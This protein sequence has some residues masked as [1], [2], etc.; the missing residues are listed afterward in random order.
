MVSEKVVFHPVGIV[1]IRPGKDNSVLIFKALKALT[2]IGIP[3][4]FLSFQLYRAGGKGFKMNIESRLFVHFNRFV[5]PGFAGY[6]L[7][8]P[9]L[10][11]QDVS[12]CF[13]FI[14]NPP[15]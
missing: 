13:V 3:L 9:A 10:L 5:E 11:F 14:H 2:A 6:E 8:D 4:A 15:E 7:P 1:L 12:Y